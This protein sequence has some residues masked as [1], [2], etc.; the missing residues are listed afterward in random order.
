[1]TVRAD[2]AAT[3]TFAEH[4]RLLFSLVYNMLGSVADT[5]DALQDIWLA[6]VGRTRPGAPPITSPRAYLVRVAANNALARR[7]AA[8]RRRETYVGP[9]LPEPLVTDTPEVRDSADAADAALRAESVS[10]AMLV[11]LESLTPLER[12]V[13]VLH[14]VFGYPHTEIAEILGRDSAAVR[15][16]AHRARAHVHDRRPRYRADPGTQ[17]AVTER[18]LAAQLGGDLTALLSLLAPDATLWSDGGGKVSAAR[19]PIHGAQH[20]VRVITGAAMSGIANSHAIEFHWVGTDPTVILLEDGIPHS[21][22][23]LDIDPATARIH[24]VYAVRNPDKLRHL[25]VPS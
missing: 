6:W 13:F 18:F 11:L 15:Q 9:W 8:S 12:A 14:E 24:G 16:T 10:T 3:A 21:V 17:R 19:H 2:D 4:R 7:Q 25:G 22:V 1:M 5:E 20:I 23:V